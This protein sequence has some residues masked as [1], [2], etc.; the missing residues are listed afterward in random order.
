MKRWGAVGLALLSGALIPLGLAPFSWTLAGLAAHALLAHTKTDLSH[1]EHRFK[2]PSEV[3]RAPLRPC[4]KCE[5]P[6][7]DEHPVVKHALRRLIFNT[8]AQFA[9][10][11]RL[12]ARACGC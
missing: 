8:R 5:V 11:A 10:A 1:L 4:Q 3:D 7:W 9:H 12:P 2:R 6:G